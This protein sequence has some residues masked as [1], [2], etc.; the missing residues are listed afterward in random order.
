[1]WLDGELVVA[2]PDTVAHVTSCRPGRMYVGLR[3]DSG[4]GPR[5]LGLPAH[6]VRDQRVPLADVWPSKNVRKISEKLAASDDPAR[7][8]EAVAAYRLAEAG[9]VDP[10]IVATFRLLSRDDSIDGVANAVGLSVRQLRRRCLAS[11]GYGPK[12]LARILRLNR[13]LDLGRAGAA[14]ADA[15][16]V[17][18]YADQAHLSRDAR[19]LGGATFT[20]LVG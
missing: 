13:A 1:M 17:T 8:L 16:A 18:G 5:V 19:S 7:V 4:A 11:F 10:V 14:A 15:A 12:T 9:P 6:K 2:G 20:A 3:F